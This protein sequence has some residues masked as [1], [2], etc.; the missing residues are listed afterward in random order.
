MRAY[1]FLAAGALALGLVNFVGK[2]DAAY[3]GSGPICVS[4]VASNDRLNVRE[5]P[6]AGYRRLGSLAPGQCGMNV[7]AVEGNWTYIRGSAFGR[8]IQGWVNNR[9]LAP[10]RTGGGPSRSF[11][12]VVN[13][14]WNDR[15][16]IRAGRSA[17]TA[18][19]GSIAPDQCGVEVR[20]RRG[21]WKRVHFNGVTGWAAARY[22]R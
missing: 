1:M 12:C 15:L 11:Q 8:N 9:Y 21:G 10:W 2:A 4:G 3:R 13:V 5:G 6:G 14:A 16:N 18:I 19:I 22:L 7:E 20:S 17:R